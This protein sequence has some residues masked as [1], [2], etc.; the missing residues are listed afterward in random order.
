M[1]FVVPWKVVELF[2]FVDEVDAVELFAQFDDIVVF[3]LIVCLF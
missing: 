2:V 3:E 1:D